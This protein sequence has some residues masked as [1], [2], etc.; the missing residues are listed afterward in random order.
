MDCKLLYKSENFLRKFIKPLKK[1]KE[2]V[3][4]I[5]GSSESELQSICEVINS[6][7]VYIHLV[8]KLIHASCE[9][10]VKKRWGNDNLKRKLILLHIPI[11]RV[12]V[13]CALKYIIVQ[14]YE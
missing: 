6:F 4:L 13:A 14:N 7:S 2:R 3:E 11:L 8:P 1:Y 10:L 12:L 9:A 5:L